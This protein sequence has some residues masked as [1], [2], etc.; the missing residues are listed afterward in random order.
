MKVLLKKLVAQFLDSADDSSHAFR[1]LY[2]I[3]VRGCEQFNLDLTG[4]IK[5]IVID[6]E[7]NKTA[8]LPVDYISYSKIGVL[9]EKGEVV[10]F[11]RNQELSTWN[12]I[13]TQQDNR[14][15]GAPVENT[16]GFDP[17]TYP[18]LY[19]NYYYEGSSFNL[20]GLDSGT[21]KLGEYKLDEVNGLILLSP[22]STHSQ[23]VLEY[24]SDGYDANTEDYEIDVRAQEAFMCWLRWNN[25][26]DLRKKFSQNDVRVYK[27]EY[28]NELRKAA[29][30]INP[31][32]LNEAQSMGRLSNKLVPK[33]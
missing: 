31:F 5:T 8:Y 3:G 25:A 23:I 15:V 19:Y 4:N 33:A 21:A 17:T 2:N 1:R 28:F 27:L 16:L 13:Y 14:R 22:T 9:N 6:V 20:F 26:K 18:Y 29:M 11:K 7:P 24:L 12:D 32:V 30:R 10:T